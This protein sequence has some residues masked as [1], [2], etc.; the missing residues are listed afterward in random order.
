MY[1][2]MTHHTL[3][4]PDGCR[5]HYAMRANGADTTVLLIHGALCD[6]SSLLP[7]GAAVAGVN[8]LLPDL[9]GHGA[10]TTA[11]TPWSLDL[12]AQDMLALVAAT[13]VNRLIVVGESFGALVAARMAER[14]TLLICSEPPLSPARLLAVR[15][16][17]ESACQAGTHQGAHGLANILGYSRAGMVASEAVTFHHL[18]RSLSVPTIL[19]HGTA[20]TGAF[21]T[22]LDR[23]DLDQLASQPALQCLAVPGADHLVLR[24]LGS[25]LLRALLHGNGAAAVTSPKV[26]PPHSD[27]SP[28]QFQRL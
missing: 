10:S 12:L 17:I 20:G 4:L 1:P 21:A 26:Y 11:A 8:L 27:T 16:A 13:P 18:M 19:L 15:A 5:L 7:V 28:V 6:A 9:R 2:D 22:V 25:C 14:V 24:D 23:H 3:P